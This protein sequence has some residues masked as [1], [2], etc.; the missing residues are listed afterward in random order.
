MVNFGEAAL[1]A[2][3]S[4]SPEGLIKAF[5]DGKAHID[6][7]VNEGKY[8]GEAISAA[9]SY[10]EGDTMLHMAM[11]N[12]KWPIRQACVSNLGADAYLANKI[13]VTPPGMQIQQSI[14]RFGATFI[15]GNL[16]Y[17][18]VLDFGPACEFLIA[19]FF[20]VMLVD[21]CLAFRWWLVAYTAHYNGIAK[22]G[23]M[24]KK[25]K[26]AKGKGKD[27]KK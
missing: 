12:K 14:P 2:L 24:A 23:G 26:E 5:S 27:K 22:G 18:K 11:R 7:T 9:I 8:G 6:A 17:R 4:N 3:Q 21:L 19:M 1:N 13:G 20:T 25:P 15:V 16:M 10:E